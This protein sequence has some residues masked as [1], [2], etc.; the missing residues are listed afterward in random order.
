MFAFSSKRLMF[1][2]LFELDSVKFNFRL[3]IFR[4]GD[5]PIQLGKQKV[6]N[7]G[8]RRLGKIFFSSGLLTIFDLFGELIS[9]HFKGE[10]MNFLRIAQGEDIL[11]FF[12]SMNN[13]NGFINF[14]DLGE[15]TLT[16][17]LVSLIVFVSSKIIILADFK[18]II[19]KNK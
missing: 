3:V 11:R 2:T 6:S 12:R 5:F 18:L 14:G 7:L 17:H 4:R 8:D 19:I 13:S 16:L 1:L 9:I 10:M 15:V